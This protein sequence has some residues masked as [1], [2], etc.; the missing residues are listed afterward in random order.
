MTLVDV[1]TVATIVTEAVHADATVVVGASIDTSLEDAVRVS[2]VITGMNAVEG[3]LDAQS[4]AAKAFLEKELK[5]QQGEEGG[6]QKILNEIK[7][8]W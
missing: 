5:R 3:S 7:K 8:W 2:L 4:R 1:E 6:M